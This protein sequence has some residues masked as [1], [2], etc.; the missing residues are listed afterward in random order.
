MHHL[1]REA[2]T[3][4]AAGFS[5]GSIETHRTA[6]GRTTPSFQVSA[7]EMNTLATAFHGLPY[8][9]LQTVDDFSAARGA[10]EEDK[11]H[12]HHEYNK[13]EAMARIAGRPVAIS[14]MDRVFAPM[15]SPWLGKAAL[16]SE[17]RG[18]DVRLACAPRGVGTLL[19]LDTTM[20]CCSPSRATRGP[21]IY[22]RPN[23]PW[24][25]AT[26]NAGRAS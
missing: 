2:M 11:S 10:P 3:A 14:W 21:C 7:R 18:V 22:H 13:I 15:Q 12:F 6:A 5:M 1:L 20:N 26:A 24:R 19:G 23:A 4:A 25:C 17:Q 8:R 9:I 16:Q